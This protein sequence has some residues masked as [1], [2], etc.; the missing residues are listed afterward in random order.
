MDLYNLIV[1]TIRKFLKEK[2][3]DLY[4]IHYPVKAVV[5]KSYEVFVDIRLLDKYGKAN[6]EYPE[7]PKVKVRNSYMVGDVVRVGFYYNDLG[8]PY[9][10]G[11]VD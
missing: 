2:H 6:D 11:K 9:V 5:T 1:R 8:M 4:S 3:P 7:I 10:D